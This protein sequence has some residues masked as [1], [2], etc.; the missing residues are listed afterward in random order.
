[1]GLLRWVAVILL[2]AASPSLAWADQPIH[3]PQIRDEI[4]QVHANFMAMNPDELTFIRMSRH[5]AAAIPSNIMIS[6]TV[7]SMASAYIS[8][9]KD[10]R[11]SEA[12]SSARSVVLNIER[13]FKE[14]A[15][16]HREKI[17]V[18]YYFDLNRYMNIAD[19]QPDKYCKDWPQNHGFPPR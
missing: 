2:G 15:P 19:D 9:C 8:E 7:A 14:Y 12:V 5:A 13:E 11:T 18:A 17:I 16:W 3:D 6:V 4:N 10:Y 1:M